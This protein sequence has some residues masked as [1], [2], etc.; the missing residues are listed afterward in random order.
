MIKEDQE[1]DGGEAVEALLEVD[2]TEAHLVQAAWVPED[3]EAGDLVA[4]A[5]SPMRPSSLY[6]LRNAALLLE[7]VERPS[8]KSTIS[9]VPMLS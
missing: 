9:L 5:T 1:W 4:T 6:P 3:L 8:G 7:K 2:S